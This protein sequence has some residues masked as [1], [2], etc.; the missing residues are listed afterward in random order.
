MLSDALTGSRARRATMVVAALVTVFATADAFAATSLRFYGNGV[1]APDLDRVKIQIDEVADTNPGPPADI[2]TQDFTI[3]LW[4]T[5]AAA[6]N[7]AGAVSCGNDIN[8]IYG[9]IVLDRDRY[10]QGR[11]FGISLAGSRWVFGVSADSADFTVCGSSDVLDGL[12][13]HVA[14]QREVA[15]GDLS[16]YVDGALDGSGTGPPGDIS[17]PDDGTPCS[18]C[19]GGPCNNSDPFMV[20]G[21]EKHDAGASFPS[22]GGFLDEIRL[23]DVVR[24]AAP[25]LRPSSPF[26]ADANTVALYHLDEGAGDVI[27]DSS[28]HPDG[29][30]DGERRFGGSP[31]GPDWSTDHPFA[32]PGD[33]DGDGKPDS[34]DPCTVL[35][36]SG[37]SAD[38]AKLQL[39]GLDEAAGLQALK[40]KG[41]FVPAG[42][43]AVEPHVNGVHLYV[44]DAVGALLDVSIPPGLVGV[45]PSTPCDAEDGWSLSGSAATPVYTYRNRSSF[46][47]GAC[48]V[49]VGGI[50]EVR[51]KDGLASS[52]SSVAFQV[53]TENSTLGPA[54]PAT[55]LVADF[56]LAAQPVPGTASPQAISGQC[57]E[58][59]WDP[60][61]GIPPPPFCKATPSTGAPA[62]LQCKGP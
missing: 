29:P 3:E 32:T 23:S 2:G 4:M 49:S 36:I 9:N 8:W 15:S 11:K 30:S 56:T 59:R 53:K 46:I 27:G 39:S 31:A 50:R 34:A 44:E 22:Y 33:L 35:L 62:K 13:H 6:D 52:S 37:Q 28:G 61:S 55:R 42:A 10:S 47:D 57:A 51:L 45:H 24:Y 40:W 48:A 14:F 54:L 38:K 26:T 43:A 19:C 12:W 25:F 20:L 41:R 1:A 18:S 7:S 16:I 5:A 60:V 17:Y 58:S 21:A